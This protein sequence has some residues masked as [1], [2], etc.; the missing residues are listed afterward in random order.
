VSFEQIENENDDDEEEDC[1][2]HRATLKVGREW[3]RP[4]RAARVT[5]ALR[6]S[7]ELLLLL[8]PVPIVP[9][10]VG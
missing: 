1:S 9:L 2:S 3:L 4:N 7:L 6:L 5:K 10:P 8:S